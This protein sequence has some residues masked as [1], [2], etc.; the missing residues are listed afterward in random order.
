MEKKDLLLICLDWIAANAPSLIQ[1]LG[2]MVPVMALAVV[3]Y[4]LHVT[5]KKDGRK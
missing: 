1:L 4:T 3:G 2:A 5:H